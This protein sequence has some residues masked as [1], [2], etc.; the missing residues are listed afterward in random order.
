MKYYIETRKFLPH[1]LLQ[2]CSLQQRLGLVP[3]CDAGTPVRRDGV[4]K[5]GGG[6]RKPQDH[7][8]E[9]QEAA[10]GS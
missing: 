6:L 5:V 2:E 10:A 3:E 7:D 9:D 4:R 1:A 8:R